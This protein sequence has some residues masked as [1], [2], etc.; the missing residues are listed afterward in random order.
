MNYVIES[1][2]EADE[3]L[4]DVF[5]S[6]P[7]PAAV[8]TAMNEAEQILERRPIGSSE[9]LSEGLRR[10]K[11]EPILVYFRVDVGRRLV[12]ISNIRLMAPDA[13]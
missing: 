7:A 2:T 8:T 9:S 4:A 6:A 11:V 13:S 10:Q 12:E 3:D 1:T 5:M